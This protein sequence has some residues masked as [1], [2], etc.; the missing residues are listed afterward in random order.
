MKRGVVHL[1]GAGPGATGLITVR[2]RDCLSR[3][4]VVIYDNLCNPALLK[5]APRQAEIIFA[6]KHSGIR[7]LSQARI[8]QIMVRRA[9]SGKTVV[10][11]KG[12][13]PFVFGRGGE[14]A[15]TLRRHRIEF[16]IVPG[17]TSAIAVPAYAGIPATHRDHA[18]GVLIVTAYEDPGKSETALDYES[19]ARFSGTLVILMGVKRLGDL[20]QRLLACGKSPRTPAALIRWGTRGMQRTLTGSLADIAGKAEQAD[21]RP[22]A[23]AVFGDVV[24]CRRDL[25]WFERR[26]LFRKRVV[27]TRTREQASELAER[28]RELGAE[29]VELPTI[30]IQRLESPALRSAVRR[31][32]DWDWVFFASPWAVDVF[33]D[34]VM[35]GRGDVRALAK[36]RFGVIGPATAARLTARGLHADLMPEPHTAREFARRISNSR[37]E[38][39]DRKVL[40]PRSRIGRDEIETALRKAGAQVQPVEVY[41][42]V[43]PRLTWEIEALERIGADV[44]TFTSSS[45]AVHFAALLKNRRL[46][47]PATRT[48]LGR[49][50]FVSIGPSTSEAMRWAGLKVHAEARP[51]TMDGL[52][53]AVRRVA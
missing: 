16:E 21:F 41:R 24:R 22:P 39:S 5:E 6:G 2:G 30:E 44:V 11:L 43:T 3:A 14:E 20:T 38:I 19:L 53:R 51:H 28:L 26:P 17:V 8:E 9:K 12:G 52:L 36:A 13:D 29:A 34:A 4:D 10:R 42:N 32:A 37:F 18:S 46:I 7:T 45:T 35:R 47:S 27:V 49:C 1:V 15:A 40:L 31:A 23:V 33:L 50:R 25:M 48:M